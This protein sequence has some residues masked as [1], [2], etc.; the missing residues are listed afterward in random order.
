MYLN[1]VQF[2]NINQIYQIVEHGYI[3]IFIMCAV[4]RTLLNTLTV[5]LH[6]NRCIWV[7]SI[8]CLKRQ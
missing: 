3:C 1:S 5:H 6:Q 8:S 2:L 4:G 7:L